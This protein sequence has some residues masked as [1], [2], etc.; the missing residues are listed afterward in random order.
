MPENDNHK[1]PR[2]QSWFQANPHLTLLLVSICIGVLGGYGAVLFRFAIKAAQG[3]FFG[4]TGDFLEFAGGLPRWMLLAMPAL[5]G[6]AVGLLVHYGAPE[7]KGHGVPEVMEAVLLKGGRIRNRV[8]LVKILASA[9]CIGSGGSV[10]REG[11]I[12]QIGSGVGSTVGQM[13]R[14]SPM[15]QK[16]LVGCGAAAGIAATFNAPIAGVLFALEVLLGDFGLTSF[17][18]IVLSSVTATV[19]SRHYFGDFP[20]FVIP[21]YHVAS[22]WEYLLYPLLGLLC[23]LVAVLFV[24]S[25]YAAE[26]L[27]E[28]LPLPWLAKPVLGGLLLGGLLLWLPQVFGVGYGAINLALV[29]RLTAP[30]LLALVLAKILATS[31]TIGSGGSGGVFAPS[32]FVGAMTGGAFG[33]AIHALLP[34]LTANP[35]AYALVA[36]GALVAGST[37]ASITAILIIFEMTNDYQIILPLMISCILSTVVAVTIKKGNIYTLK[38]LRR[39]VNLQVNANL[40]LL[41]ALAVRDHMITQLET[42]PEDL[43]L[44][45]VLRIFGERNA[46]YLHVLDAQGQLRGII[47]FRDI[48]AFLARGPEDVR[49]ITAR[50]LA[51]TG[52]TVIFPGDSLLAALQLMCN[53]GFAQLPVVRPENGQL[54]G[55]LRQKDLLAIY[56]QAVFNTSPAAEPR[57]QVAGLACPIKADST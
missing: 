18:P 34:G 35:G 24:T 1:A 43:P 57:G 20:A 9:I 22:A 55:T 26:D 14:V 28:A 21:A 11:P 48:R 6:L 52:L 32:L 4:Q 27:F 13:L 50:D 5:G 45:D 51:T 54:V 46:S 17:S 49:Q 39:G 37:H 2:G 25:L 56:G 29:D 12:V 36:M 16:T 40:S 38:L 42:V 33:W 10:G 47:S 23:G 3:L 31:V 44:A 7:A 30:L 41:R 19:I 8:A 15:Q 53:A